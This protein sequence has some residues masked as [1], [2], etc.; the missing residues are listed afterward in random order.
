MKFFTNRR[1]LLAIVFILSAPSEKYFICWNARTNFFRF[2]TDEEN[3]WFAGGG[4]GFGVV[5]FPFKNHPSFYLN[6]LFGYSNLFHGFEYDVNN[7]G[8]EIC[9][10]TGSISVDRL[11]TELTLQM[12]TS[13]KSLYNGTLKNPII[14]NLTL[15]YIFWKK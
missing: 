7:F 3:E 4:A 1:I 12:G 2:E 5:F 6:C 8:T 11:S 10:G 15:N 9:F 14:L 13:E